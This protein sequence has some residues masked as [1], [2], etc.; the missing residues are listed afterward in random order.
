MMLSGKNDLLRMSDPLLYLFGQGN[1]CLLHHVAKEHQLLKHCLI[2]LF[3]IVH[4]IRRWQSL[5][6]L[7]FLLNIEHFLDIDM[8][9]DMTIDLPC[10]LIVD[11]MLVC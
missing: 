7:H 11:M 5:H 1:E 10:Q 9:L 8:L 3:R 6:K 2:C 4:T